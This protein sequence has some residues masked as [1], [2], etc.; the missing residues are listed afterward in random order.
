MELQ[1]LTGCLRLTRKV[2]E[3][4]PF[5][6]SKVTFIGDSLCCVM[7]LRNDGVNYNAYFQHR[8]CEVHENL[9]KLSELVDEVRPVQWVES[10]LNPADLVTKPGTRP[11]DLVSGGFW[12]AGPQFLLEAFEDWPV[13]VPTAEGAVPPHEI[14]KGAEVSVVN[15]AVG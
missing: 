8:L 10:S 9:E 2:V 3:A 12:Q 5:S 6:V 14:K 11:G 4:L 7:A 13:S 1:G 15:E